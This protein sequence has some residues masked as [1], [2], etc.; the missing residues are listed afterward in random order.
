MQRTTPEG[1]QELQQVT[2]PLLTEDGILTHADTRM[3]KTVQALL[4]V[5]YLR[6]YN[7]LSPS[8]SVQVGPAEVQLQSGSASQGTQAAHN[9]PCNIKLDGR[10]VWEWV[11]TSSTSG[12]L[13][14]HSVAGWF[15]STVVL[16]AVVNKCDSLW[17][18][19]GLKDALARALTHV[20]TSH[21]LD[22]APRPALLSAFELFRQGSRTALVSAQAHN[23]LPQGAEK[24][25]A[26][27]HELTAMTAILNIYA[28]E[29]ER[30]SPVPTI[31][32]H[33]S[34]SIARQY[35][36]ALHTTDRP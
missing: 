3:E 11:P 10:N 20:V 15:A 29:L 16:P 33:L 27:Q 23:R 18:H 30:F 9:M 19:R 26:K 1:W 4:V 36:E 22:T 34:E 7:R 2:S 12:S 32:A 5:Y 13:L 6:R 24:S 8:A 17:E 35:A 28:R 31:T 21:G 14:R 25:P